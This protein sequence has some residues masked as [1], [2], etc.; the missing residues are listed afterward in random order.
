V[1]APQQA[2]ERVSVAVLCCGDEVDVTGIG[3]VLVRRRQG[4]RNYDA[5]TRISAIAA[6]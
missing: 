6:A 2:V 4:P 3:V 1:V 5:K